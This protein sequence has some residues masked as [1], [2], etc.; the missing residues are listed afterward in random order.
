MPWPTTEPWE[1]PR[2][3]YCGYPITV[4]DPGRTMPNGDALHMQADICAHFMIRAAAEKT[5]A[6]EAHADAAAE[7]DAK[8]PGPA[9]PQV[10]VYGIDI[11]EW[12]NRWKLFRDDLTDIH[13]ALIHLMATGGSRA[14]R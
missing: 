12:D 1:F 3:S 6:A 11:T 2:C 10:T 4:N 14:D 7:M 5:A 9:E 13:R 8:S